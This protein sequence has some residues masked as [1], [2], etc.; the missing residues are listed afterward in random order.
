MSLPDDQGGND[1]DTLS[2]ARNVDDISLS[3]E[4]VQ[5]RRHGECIGK[6]V[7]LS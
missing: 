1:V 7:D 4:D 6:V 3:D 2:D 5:P